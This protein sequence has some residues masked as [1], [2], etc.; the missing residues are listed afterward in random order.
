MPTWSSKNR[1]RDRLR[2]RRTPASAAAVGRKRSR[3]GWGIAATGRLSESHPETQLADVAFT[4]REDAFDFRRAVGRERSEEASA[5]WEWRA[6]NAGPRRARRSFSCSPAA[7]RS[8]AV[9]P[10]FIRDHR[11]QTAGRSV[12]TGSRAAG[13][14]AGRADVQCH[15]GQLAERPSVGLPTFAIEFARPRSGWLGRE[16]RALIGHSL[17]EYA[18]AC[19]SGVMALNDAL[20]LVARAAASCRPIPRA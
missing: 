10:R 5:C 17:G 19:L 8:T 9:P 20:L 15:D 3:A 12:R 13:R 7:A 6:A 18:A 16:A 1:L 14:H 11:I 4:L 2:V